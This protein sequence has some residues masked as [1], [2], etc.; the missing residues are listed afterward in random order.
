[1]ASLPTRA[2]SAVLPGG[3]KARGAAVGYGFV[4]MASALVVMA[5]LV[6]FFLH[7]AR[8]QELERRIMRGVG[9]SSLIDQVLQSGLELVSV[10]AI[11]LALV[12]LAVFAVMR[13]RADLGLGAAILVA[14]ANITTQ[15]L[16]YGVLERSDFGFSR[17]NSLPSGHVTV[18]TSLLIAA[19]LVLPA[20][21]RP[22]LAPAAAF[23]ATGA[24][25]GTIVLSWHRPSDVIAAYAVVLWWVGA[26]VACLALAWRQQGPVPRG[27][28]RPFGYVVGGFLAVVVAAVLML[29][30]GV[31]PRQ[32]MYDLALGLAA[33]LL[34]ALCC[35]AVISLAAYATDLLGDDRGTG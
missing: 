19:V 21:W 34:V 25:V 15:V 17:H 32:G 26:I 30:S 35:A 20:A 27:L 7:D 22:M 5:F 1:M 16:K 29:V 18:I 3:R 6:R 24:G 4:L 8:G 2:V 23:L 31:S 28:W 33:L 13:R 11:V 12:A 14:G 10:G 9:T